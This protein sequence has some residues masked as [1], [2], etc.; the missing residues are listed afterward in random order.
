MPERAKAPGKRWPARRVS[1]KNAKSAV[2]PDLLVVGVLLLED[3]LNN[4]KK[5]KAKSKKE[6]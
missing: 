5:Y 2:V 1:R 4:G 3:L 6:Y